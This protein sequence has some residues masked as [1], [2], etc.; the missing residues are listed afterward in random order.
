MSTNDPLDESK[1]EILLD[2]IDALRILRAETDEERDQLLFELAGSGRVEQEM[3]TQM[4]SPLPLLHPERFEEAHRY[5]V[6]GLEVLDRNGPRSP[7]VKG[8]GPLSPVIQ[9]LAQQVI[10]FIVRSY[11][12]KVLRNICGL[13]ERR[14]AASSWS[15]PEHSMLRRCSLDISRVK[16]GMNGKALGLPTFIFGGAIFTS[17]ASGLRSLSELALGN[18]IGLAGF[19]AVLV[20]IF[21]LLSWLA[22]Y[23]SGIARKR[24]KISIDQP[25][26]ALYE[27]IGFA[28]KPPKDESG[29]FAVFAIIF[30]AL[31]WLIV[32]L[33]LIV[34]F[35]V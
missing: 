10:R 5:M 13:Y 31:S 28:G 6:R 15:S 25:I 33:S 24:I 11:Q 26:K 21:L 16:E 29:N 19:A 34:L 17:V 1:T 8:F 4:S 3:L 18:S 2:K 7:R 32:P 20:A 27:T 12:E 30:L 22:L 9:W 23:S 35:A 14:E